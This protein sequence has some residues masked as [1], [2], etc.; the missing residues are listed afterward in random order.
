M[1]RFS[2]LVLITILGGS[3]TSAADRPNIVWVTSE[4]NG[5]HLGCYGDEYADTPR[6]DELASRS[7]RYRTCWS[8][9]PVCAPA[10]TTLISG[11]YATS[12][13]GH[14]MRSEVR[15]PSAMKL[16]PAVLHDAGYFCT[17]NSKTD[18]NFVSGADDAGWDEN[19][20]QASFRNRPSPDTP[21]F[22]V[23]NFTISHESK[24]RNQPHTLVHDPAD[25]PVPSYHPDVPEVRRDWAQYY[26]RLTEMDAMVGEVLD[27]LEEDGLTDSTIIFYYGDH[28]SGMPRSKR[29]PF[30]S[31]L[32]VPLIVHVPEKFQS[33]APQNYL[34]G[35]VSNQLVSFVDCGPTA[36]SL[37]GVEPPAN[38]QG[39][40]FAGPHAGEPKEYLFG[41]RGRMDE[42]IDRVRSCTD[43]RFV[44]LRHF[45]PDRPY[46]KYIQYMFQT[47]T[48]RVWKEMF[49]AGQL[50]EVQA[51]VWKPKPLEELF[52]LQSDPDEVVNLAQDP[53]YHDQL[54]AMQMAL[55]TWMI[56]TRDL[57][58]LPE[59][60]FLQLAGDQSPREYG[61]SDEFVAEALVEAAWSATKAW[62]TPDQA[63]VALATGLLNEPHPGL[64]YWGAR[65]LNLALQS[66]S[67][68][69]SDGGT[70][71][72]CQ[73]LADTLDDDDPAVAI[74]AA[75]ALLI[76]GSDG[77]RRAAAQRLAFLANVKNTS[78]PVAIAALNVVDTHPT[79]MGVAM[80]KFGERFPV[81][82]PD[83]P[84]RINKYV[85]NLMKHLLTQ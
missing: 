56:E 36:I 51:K 75:E 1:R 71:A 2:F 78:H 49:D 45:Y 22:S 68:I 76:R 83:S 37:A 64:R 46:L 19:G 10:R 17:N 62:E 20:K 38:M 67:D 50:N 39:V 41:Y 11:M 80:E 12:L 30:N 21:F 34:P 23:F 58:V 16:Y 29:W 40:P 59:A 77:Q 5:P 72:I 57:G 65:G 14:H 48:T 8:N 55:K 63:T 28:G 32:H 70:T 24:I 31:G 47:P 44:Y 85:G 84:R 33:L 25:A 9:A 18:Y 73:T 61:L 27:Q 53:A 60:Q 15:L 79:E 82:V 13:G 74:A 69:Q 35:G 42:R 6:L 26:D 54:T 7:L 52:D 43:G 3:F 4:D 81:D 66:R